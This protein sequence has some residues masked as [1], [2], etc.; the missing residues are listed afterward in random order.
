MSVYGNVYDNFMVCTCIIVCQFGT[1]LFF[2]LSAPHGMSSFLSRICQV[3]LVPVELE[4]VI[5]ERSLSFDSRKFKTVM[6]RSSTHD[7]VAI[8]GVKCSIFFTMI[9]CRSA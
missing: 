4:L 6:V 7:W 8:F 5:G 2:D 3:L 9:K 1:T